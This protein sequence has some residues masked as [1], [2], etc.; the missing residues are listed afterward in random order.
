MFLIE[1][2]LSRLSTY[3]C[4]MCPEIKR[5]AKLSLAAAPLYH[6][7]ARGLGSVREGP[8][9]TR[10][11]R[12]PRRDRRSAGGSL[13]GGRLSRP[14][15]RGRPRS[16]RC[17]RNVHVWGLG[18][19]HDPWTTQGG[20]RWSRKVVWGLAHGIHPGWQWNRW[21]W[22]KINKGT[23]VDRKWARPFPLKGKHKLPTARSMW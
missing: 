1:Y 15:P 3:R 19:R 21:I 8:F 4:L 6:S 10:V 14:E 5:I 12:S 7:F 16:P 23:E 22:K 13:T 11:F 18:R 9:H 20:W 17:G 2:V